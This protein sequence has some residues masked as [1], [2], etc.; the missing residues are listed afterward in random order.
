MTNF[1]KYVSESV[2]TGVSKLDVYNAQNLLRVLKSLSAS[3][4]KNISSGM[5]EEEM[6]KELQDIK[7]LLKGDILKAL[8][9]A[10]DYAP[11]VDSLTAGT[12]VHSPFP[13]VDS[14]AINWLIE[15]KVTD[16]TTLAYNLSLVK[17][18][19][20]QLP[21]GGEGVQ[22]EKNLVYGVDYPDR[23]LKSSY[24]SDPLKEFLKKEYGIGLSEDER[25][26][27]ERD[28]H[29]KEI[30]DLYKKSADTL[31]G[32]FKW[33]TAPA[34]PYLEIAK[35]VWDFAKPLRKSVGEGFDK[36]KDASKYLG[37]GS[38][39][40]INNAWK[41]TQEERQKSRDIPDRGRGSVNNTSVGGAS[42]SATSEEL[43]P[44]TINFPASI[45]INNYEDFEIWLEKWLKPML[46]EGYLTD[47]SISK[48]L[49]SLMEK[50]DAHLALILHI[51]ES[52]D[53]PVLREAVY[54]YGIDK[55]VKEQGLLP[56]S[57]LHRKGI[58]SGL[59]V[60]AV[61]GKGSEEVSRLDDFASFPD[62]YR[63]V[64]RRVSQ[65]LGAFVDSGD[66]YESQFRR[67]DTPLWSSIHRKFRPKDI[68][69]VDFEDITDKTYKQEIERDK[70]QEIV[71]STKSMFEG[72]RDS[73]EDLKKESKSESDES[74]GLL[75][76]LTGDKKDS[77]FMI[78]LSSIL[79]GF[80][81]LLGG[82]SKF[83]SPAMIAGIGT[84]VAYFASEDFRGFVNKV[85]KVIGGTVGDF[86]NLSK[87][88]GATESITSGTRNAAI[89]AF[90]GARGLG[91]AA[92]Y[93]GK[94]AQIAN[95]AANI[96]EIGGGSSATLRAMSNAN[97]VAETFSK[98]S[99]SKFMKIGGK[100][101]VLGAGV[102]GLNSGLGFLGLDA[103][104]NEMN[105]AG[106]Y[107]LFGDL[108]TS[109]FVVDD[110]FAKSAGLDNLTWK[111]YV[112]SALNGATIGALAGGG[113]ASAITAAAGSVAAVAALSEEAKRDYR[114]FAKEN[115]QA[116][117]QMV[118]AK[119]AGVSLDRLSFR[120]AD[121]TGTDGFVKWLQD[122]KSEISNA[123][124][125]SGAS[126]EGLY[127][128]L[129]GVWY[130]SRA[131]PKTPIKDLPF[132]AVV[133][134]VMPY[135]NASPVMKDGKI[136]DVD[137]SVQPID[138]P[139]RQIFTRS[140]DDA[141]SG[142]VFRTD[143]GERA[144][145]V[146][147]LNEIGDD[148]DAGRSQVSSV[149]GVSRIRL[150][151]GIKKKDSSIN[152]VRV[153][154]PSIVGF[155]NGLSGRSDLGDIVITSGF[156]TK[157]EQ[158]ALSRS[159][160]NKYSTSSSPH[161]TGR[162]VDIR[163]TKPLVDFFASR[164][165][166]EYLVNNNIDPAFLWGEIDLG[167]KSHFHVQPRQSTSLNNLFYSEEGWD[168]YKVYADLRKKKIRMSGGQYRADGDKVLAMSSDEAKAYKAGAYDYASAASPLPDLEVSSELDSAEFKSGEW[169][170]GIVSAIELLGSPFKVSSGQVSAE[171]GDD[172]GFVGVAVSRADFRPPEVKPLKLKTPSLNTDLLTTS[173]TKEVFADGGVGAIVSSP[174]STQV[175]TNNNIV[176]VKSNL[177]TKQG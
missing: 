109:G 142:D 155:V 132:Q 113:I 135:V 75:K 138:L 36:F 96:A 151:N 173:K 43:Q 168:R 174:T 154:D 133:G 82:F 156:R 106:G 121:G 101:G 118:A 157:E 66:G 38:I 33:M 16:P 87:R 150:G 70:Q 112:S 53:L 107:D 140:V 139:G 159:N 158:E 94:N 98:L 76:E 127:N 10:K 103:E 175:V 90:A 64:S 54:S 35:N 47:V 167:E 32:Q 122:N 7:A 45:S 108:D 72:L 148:P 37:K 48:A 104:F 85:G 165:G 62:V 78:F 29:D 23:K 116:F 126:K 144:K 25:R 21:S 11:T 13:K 15:K 51:S 97:K 31:L 65:D 79:S 93:F 170:S 115:P 14:S 80:T 119:K 39:D 52:L 22:Q 71:D 67:E 42:V 4:N 95:R 57:S 100:V 2:P 160:G 6:L 19:W 166:Y 77:P 105:N 89:G 83:F 102:E 152:V 8:Q 147:S 1:D 49:S 117:L 26:Q 27:R 145:I 163:I 149:S 141:L 63:G 88:Q 61:I 56:E 74:Q 120:R 41:E 111:N 3:L 169:Y 73:I 44:A 20:N 114:Q 86:F 176:N 58:G 60:P 143:K 172:S 18:L 146:R 91:E 153:T 30:R 177:Y 171:A 123:M 46:E 69:D 136:V 24:D 110:A 161:L 162:A 81:S 17:R 40:V 55:V 92:N 125:Y 5:F 129:M 84:L 130:A 12:S 34:S 134:L 28:R 131:N 128:T 9:R 164:E 50:S 99:A 137:V 124:S 68:E 59:G